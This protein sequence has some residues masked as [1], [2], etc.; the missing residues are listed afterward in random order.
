MATR[1]KTVDAL[2]IS[3]RGRERVS[4]LLSRLSHKEKVALLNTRLSRFRSGKPLK[5]AA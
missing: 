5:I 4:A 2:A 1:K 3:R